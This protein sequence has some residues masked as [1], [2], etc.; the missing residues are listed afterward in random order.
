MIRSTLQLLL[1]IGITSFSPVY[2]GLVCPTGTKNAGEEQCVDVSYSTH[3]TQQCNDNTLA[4]KSLMTHKSAHGDILIELLGPADVKDS[5]AIVITAPHG[6]SLKPIYIKTRKKRGPYCDGSCVVSKD[7]YTKEIALELGQKLIDNYCKVPYVVINHLHRS[8]L[9]ANREIGEAAQGDPIAESAWLEFHDFIQEAQTKILSKHGEVV[10]TKSEVAIKGLLLDVH[11]YAGTDFV[12][13]AGS[14]FIQWGYRMSKTSLDPNEYCKLDSR[15]QGTIGTYTH[16][17]FMPDQSLECLV[18]GPNSLGSRVASMMP[19]AGASD[20]C[21]LGLPS[22]EFPS[23]KETTND[24]DYCDDIPCHYYSGGYDVNVH[25]HLYWDSKSGNMMN[26]VQMELPR[27]IRF[28][29][30]TRSGR[31]ETH[32]SFADKLSIALCSFMKD[33]FQDQSICSI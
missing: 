8:K 19:I 3:P 13:T 32:N 18:R 16:A 29:D 26:T 21:G 1:I 6:G 30:G 25:E 10:N 33:L 9:D 2:S 23:P 11:G 31:K 17:R 5:A 27:C 20:S 28:A 22:F 4:L 24:P 14:P 7:S 12:P 15:S